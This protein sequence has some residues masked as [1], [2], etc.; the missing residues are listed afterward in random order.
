MPMKHS[1]NPLLYRDGKR[2]GPQV[3]DAYMGWRS[4]QV[5]PLPERCDNKGCIFHVQPLE[6][7]SKPLRPTLDHANG[8]NTDNRPKNL[9]LLCPNC[10]S[11]LTETKGGANKGK[12]RKSAGGFARKDANGLWHYTLPAEP[13]HV[14]V[15]AQTADFRLSEAK[16]QANKSAA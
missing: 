9:R 5:P 6:W 16:L 15:T 7:N 14:A 12:V 1:A 3:Y 11:Q 13:F 10:D 2:K 4:S 8:V